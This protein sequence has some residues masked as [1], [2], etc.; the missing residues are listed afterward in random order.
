LGVDPDRI[1][2]LAVTFQGLQPVG[3]ERDEISERGGSI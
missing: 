2:T 3:V 1:L